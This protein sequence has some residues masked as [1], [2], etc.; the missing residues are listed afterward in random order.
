MPRRTPRVV[1]YHA[2]P[3]LALFLE[4]EV[5]V[6][7]RRNI[8]HALVVVLRAGP[9]VARDDDRELVLRVAEADRRLRAAVAVGILGRV[10]AS[11]AADTWQK[12][13]GVEDARSAASIPCVGCNSNKLH[14]VFFGA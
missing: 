6:D 3:P 14:C 5:L 12:A 11:A 7:S 2:W 8:M 9:R 1:R 10:D 13:R 4:A